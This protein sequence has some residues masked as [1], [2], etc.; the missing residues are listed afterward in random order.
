MFVTP[1]ARFEKGLSASL[2][3]QKSEKTNKLNRH[4]AKLETIRSFDHSI[5]NRI[6]DDFTKKMK[7]SNNQL[8]MKGLA[9]WSYEHVKHIL[10]NFYNLIF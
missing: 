2:E 8:K 5:R 4:N 1:K 9:Q 3:F 6:D 7:A 10:N